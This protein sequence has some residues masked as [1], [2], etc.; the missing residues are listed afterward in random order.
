MDQSHNASLPADL[1]QGM[2]VLLDAETGIISRVVYGTSDG[3]AF[4]LPICAAATLR[5]FGNKEVGF[6]KA[7]TA[8]E[9][10]IGAIGEAL[11]IYASSQFNAADLL[12]ESLDNLGAAALDPRDLCL[13]E[14][15]T[16]NRPG[17]PYTR[18]DPTPAIHWGR[19]F[20][21]PGGEPVWVPASATFRHF[22]PP[23][24]MR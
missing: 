2:R 1:M 20:S 22:P 21:L 12:I 15:S 4:C 9:A 18:F 16:Y 19:R 3:K 10:M 6:G 5:R 11:E 23:P 8:G 24:E 7:L 17:F 14:D 13:Y